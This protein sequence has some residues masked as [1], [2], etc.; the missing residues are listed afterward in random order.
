MLLTLEVSWPSCF[1]IHLQQRRQHASVCEK[2][3]TMNKGV[4]SIFHYR[5]SLWGNNVI[6]TP[7][8]GSLWKHILSTYYYCKQGLNADL[9]CIDDIWQQILLW[10]RRESAIFS[11]TFSTL[12]QYLISSSSYVAFIPLMLKQSSLKLLYQVLGLLYQVCLVCPL[13]REA[14][15]KSKQC[16]RSEDNHHKGCIDFETT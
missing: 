16:Q 6:S 10:K 1:T 15:P 2:V 14:V 13:P 4:V 3:L 7:S 12:C 11:T 9:P 8:D 5:A